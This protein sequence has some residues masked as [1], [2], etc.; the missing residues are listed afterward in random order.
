MPVPTD[1]G[2]DVYNSPPALKVNQCRETQD[3]DHE[4]LAGCRD[5]PRAS[6]ASAASQP[7]PAVAGHAWVCVRLRVTARWEGFSMLASNSATAGLETL[8]SCRMRR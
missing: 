1:H 6:A 8:P 3:T 7:L 4:T 2:A 5:F